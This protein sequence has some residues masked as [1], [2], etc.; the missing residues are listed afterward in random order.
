MIHNAIVQHLELGLAADTIFADG[1][2]RVHWSV[3]SVAG[4]TIGGLLRFDLGS[5]ITKP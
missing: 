1:E 2:S 5:F 3:H 4:H